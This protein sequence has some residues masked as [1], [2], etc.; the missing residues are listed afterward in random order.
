MDLLLILIPFCFLV[1]I[2]YLIDM[3]E[4]PLS[5]KVKLI[6][7]LSGFA[8]VLIFILL[9][10]HYDMLNPR[11][12]GVYLPTIDLVIKGWAIAGTILI[13]SSVSLALTIIA[14]V[15]YFKKAPSQPSVSEKNQENAINEVRDVNLVVKLQGRW[16]LRDLD[17]VLL[18]DE[19]QISAGSTVKGLEADTYISQG[20]HEIYIESLKPRR[21]ITKILNFTAESGKKIDITYE[22]SRAWGNYKANI[23]KT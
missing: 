18:L 4:K 16:M 8:A 13:G 14:T 9:I 21:K 11:G 3:G 22:F 20:S 12:D 7:G 23:S 6:A 17:I 5:K 1:E 19:Q 2:Y 10:G 15:K